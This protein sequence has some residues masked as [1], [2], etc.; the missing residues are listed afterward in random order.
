M[1][2]YPIPAQETR[3]ETEV[4][5]SHFI[6]TVGAVFNVEQARAFIARIR[7][8]FVDAAHNVRLS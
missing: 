5:N 4:S 2:Q 3:T 7:G 1:G 6:A 8:E